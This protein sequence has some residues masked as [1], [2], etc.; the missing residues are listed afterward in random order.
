MQDSTAKKDD[1][2]ADT[3][4]EFMRDLKESKDMSY[5][6]LARLVEYSE[7]YVRGWFASKS[8]AKYRPVPNRAVSI[9]RLKLNRKGPLI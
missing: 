2:P 9:A 8:S 3:N 1:L 7:D 6:E 4:F 5:R